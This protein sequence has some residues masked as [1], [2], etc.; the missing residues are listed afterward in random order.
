MVHPLMKETSYTIGMG[1]RYIRL[2]LKINLDH[3]VMMKTNKLLKVLMLINHFLM[4]Q[5]LIPRLGEN[6]INEIL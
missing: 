3:Q 4:L 2:T 1:M 6:K 5:A